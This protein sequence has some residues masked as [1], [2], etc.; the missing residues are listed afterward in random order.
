VV[1]PVKH[2][3]ASPVAIPKSPH[4]PAPS[5]DD[6]SLAL[7]HLVSSPTFQRP[8]TLPNPGPPPGDLPDLGPLPTPPPPSSPDFENAELDFQ[9]DA[10]RASAPNKP[11]LDQ[12]LVRIGDASADQAGAGITEASVTGA[13]SH[14]SPAR[15][16]GVAGMLDIDERAYKRQREQ[17]P[18]TVLE[19]PE[20]EPGPNWVKRLV[21]LFVSLLVLAIAYQFVIR[22]ML[23]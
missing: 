8:K 21:I 11:R 6:E 17:R 22:P 10:A 3:T 1:G 9:P 20:P 14:P 7:P 12:E 13:R 18:V 19:D 23:H 16:K 4:R 5:P 15:H 2:I